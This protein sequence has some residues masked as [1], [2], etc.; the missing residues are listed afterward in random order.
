MHILLN[1]VSLYH[2]PITHSPALPSPSPSIPPSLLLA[3]KLSHFISS[4][5]PPPPSSLISPT[6]RARDGDTAIPSRT[7]YITLTAKEKWKMTSPTYATPSSETTNHQAKGRGQ[8]QKEVMVTQESHSLGATRH[9]RYR[10]YGKRRKKQGGKAQARPD[11]TRRGEARHEYL[12]KITW[13]VGM[14]SILNVRTA[15]RARRIEK[16][17]KKKGPS[18]ARAAKGLFDYLPVRI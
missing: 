16:M 10:R 3:H 2:H 1:S 17:I 6:R 11:E 18:R 9:E 4:H 14:P 7:L 5:L 8:S 12:S 15:K 13:W